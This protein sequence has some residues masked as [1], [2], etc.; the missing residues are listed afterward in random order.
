MGALTIM[1]FGWA[2]Y[3]IT[4]EGGT[5]IVVDPY[6]NGDAWG[7]YPG[8]P[9]SPFSVGDLAGADVVAVTHAGYDHRAQ[10]IDIALAGNA[11]LVSGTALYGA[12]V[13]AG[14][15]A[16]RCAGMVPG[17]TFRHGDATIKA[18]D[19]GPHTSSM[20]VNGQFVSD[21]PLSFLVTTEAGSRIF[22]GGDFAISGEL[23]TWR[24]LY[25]P[26][27][28][29][30]GIGG[31]QNGPVNTTWLPPAEAAIAAEWLGAPRVIPVHYSPGDPNPG[32]LTRALAGRGS[33]I[34]V[35]TLEF[36]D[37]WTQP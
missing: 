8:L 27:V 16:G 31:V 20:M 1:R 23:K 12:A 25:A 30:L 28:A 11:Y 19:A 13:G 22:C 33:G 15:P 29:I 17:V 10:A 37:T 21:E 5:R 36:G 9:A 32:E 18:I 7:A 14:V 26:Q 2:G 34:E 4:T 3:V 35:I 6:L 24:E